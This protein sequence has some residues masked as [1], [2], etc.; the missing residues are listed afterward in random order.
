M[1]QR[2]SISDMDAIAQAHVL[3]RL[4]GSDAVQ[5]HTGE[6]DPVLAYAITLA[7]ARH[8]IKDLTRI[9]RNLAPGDDQ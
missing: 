5:R 8:V 2:L 6:H 1:D 7:E 9:I 3:A 4:S